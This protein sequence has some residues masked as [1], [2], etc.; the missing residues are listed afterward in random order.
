VRGGGCVSQVYGGGVSA[1]G[2]TGTG[3]G[4]GQRVG[5]SVVEGTVGPCQGWRS[6][7]PGLRWQGLWGW[8]W[9]G[10]CP[11]A[12]QTRA[13]QLFAGYGCGRGGVHVVLSSGVDLT[14]MVGPR[15]VKACRE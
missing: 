11:L 3:K 8:G 1:F 4:G 6:R 9:H 14:A 2:R 15:Q 5:K 13:L 7:Q 10:A 12:H